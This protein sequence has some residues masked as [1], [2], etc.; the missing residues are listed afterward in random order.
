MKSTKTI[1]I[2][3]L[4]VAGAA[5]APAVAL[6]GGHA[7]GA[8]TVV[9]K[10]TRF[11]PGSLTVNRRDTVT[12][13]WRDGGERHNVTFR[14]FHSHTMGKGAFTVRFMS[15]GTYSYRCTIHESEGMRGKIIVH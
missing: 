5:V 11:H 14:G 3:V 8:H 4:A 15:K 6:G 13:V 10:S 12:W 2:A 1:A 7:A 9:L